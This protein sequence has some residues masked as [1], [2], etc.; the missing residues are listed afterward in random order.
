MNQLQVL[1]KLNLVP[2]DLTKRYASK[3]LSLFTLIKELEKMDGFKV[4]LNGI[5]GNVEIVSS[6]PHLEYPENYNERHR[7]F[8]KKKQQ[9]NCKEITGEFEQW[10][11]ITLLHDKG[12][13]KFNFPIDNDLYNVFLGMAGHEIVK[14][15]KKVEILETITVQ[16][17]IFKTFTRAIKFISKDDL[18]P[19]MTC[20]C[21]SID[22]GSVEIVATDAHRLFQSKS[23]DCSKKE[24]LNILVNEH[25]AKEIAKLKPCNSTTEIHILPE[26]K[27]MIEGKVFATLDA[28][29]PD[30]KVVIPNY[31]KSMSFDRLQFISNVKKIM[32]YTNRSTCQVNLHING[33]IALSGQDV[34]F[35]FE[36]GLDMPYIKKQFID[37]D[38]AFNGKFLVDSL[39]IF[40][41]K[42]VKFY[43]DGQ[44]TK[45]GIFTN[46]IDT[47]LLMPLMLND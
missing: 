1:S 44:S 46:D 42:T 47:V 18:R 45:A 11:Q 14:T 26:D 10:Q 24:R 4:V 3:L 21:I 19:A 13:Y 2:C 37:T 40:K 34:D 5:K 25:D 12:E 39:G 9:D 38:I 33:S 17:D 6:M 27:I 15:E 16:S 20:V 36:T 22:N 23:F 41:E 28:R 31:K 8:E 30:Y 35:S 43:T 29:F 32:P 7:Y